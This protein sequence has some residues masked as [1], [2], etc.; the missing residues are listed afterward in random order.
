LRNGITTPGTQGILKTRG[1]LLSTKGITTKP[2]L[3]TSVGTMR[4]DEEANKKSVSESVRQLVRTT[5]SLKFND[6]P[7]R[8]N[9][10]ARKIPITGTLGNIFNIILIFS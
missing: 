7:I 4:A 6:S 9:S 2:I 10:F 5:K 8:S 3:K 1:T